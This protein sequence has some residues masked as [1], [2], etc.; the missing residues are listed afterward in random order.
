MA[1][2]KGLESMSYLKKKMAQQKFEIFKL[3]KKDQEL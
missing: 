2:E 3:Q 1:V